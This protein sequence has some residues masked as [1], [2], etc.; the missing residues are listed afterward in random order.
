MTLKPGSVLP[1]VTVS[2]GTAVTASPCHLGDGCSV[3]E[4]VVKQSGR[5]TLTQQGA[6]RWM[7]SVLPTVSQPANAGRKHSRIHCKR[8]CYSSLVSFLTDCMIIITYV[9]T[10]CVGL[11]ANWK[12]EFSVSIPTCM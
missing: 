11:P 5:V 9:G 8:V 7:P 3:M 1:K 6:G 4:E 12:Q 2:E 10:T